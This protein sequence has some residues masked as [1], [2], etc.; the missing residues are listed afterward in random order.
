MRITTF[1][2]RHIEEVAA[3]AV[4]LSVDH[5]RRQPLRGRGMEDAR[6]VEELLA[7]RVES[8]LGVVALEGASIAGY[9]IPVALDDLWGSAGVYV[10]ESG[11]GIDRADLVASMYGAA[12]GGWSEGGRRVQSLSMPADMPEVE[13]VWHDTCF[14]RVLVD[15]VRDLAPLEG[16]PAASIRRAELEDAATITAMAHGLWDHLDAPPVHRI[17]EP[18]DTVAAIRE[19]LGDDGRPVWLA[20]EGGAPV[21]YLSL[22]PADD[23]PL[24]GA[25]T[26][27][28]HCNGAFVVPG[29]RGSGVGHA[30]LDT[31][32]AWARD[33]GLTRIHADWETANQ[34]A[35]R[36]WPS[37]GFG[38][39]LHS[40]ARRIG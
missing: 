11:Y 13:A 3:R 14:G 19:R 36:F 21:G 31:G 39:V 29:N 10:P 7:A 6:A 35:N 18:P 38:A 32:L 40:L 4:A 28:I 8:G 34:S 33:Q 20:E 26:D 12:A 27:A 1:E 17:H 30:L 15:A 2:D 9:L 25:G 24:A 16:V 5:R 23:I 22:A 37:V